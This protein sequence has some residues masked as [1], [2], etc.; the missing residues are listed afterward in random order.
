MR[1]CSGKLSSLLMTSQRA[2]GES[3]SKL[4]SLLYFTARCSSFLGAAIDRDG[5]S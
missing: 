2:I 4:E 1:K 5:D 3:S